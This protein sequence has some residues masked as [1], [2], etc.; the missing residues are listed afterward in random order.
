[1]K[2]LGF[3]SI[4]SPAGWLPRVP[5][6]SAPGSTGMNRARCW[7]YWLDITNDNLQRWPQVLQLIEAMSASEQRDPAWAWHAAPA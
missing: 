4:F 3:P 1:M 2:C 7:A 6:I 5:C